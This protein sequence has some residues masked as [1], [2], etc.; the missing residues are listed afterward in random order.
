MTLY[1]VELKVQ[2]KT[3]M[4]SKLCILEP[5]S[6]NVSEGSLLPIKRVDSHKQF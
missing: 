6:N 2:R 5:D 3:L 1:K 4:D